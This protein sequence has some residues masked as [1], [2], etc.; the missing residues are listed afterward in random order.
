MTEFH[1]E[2]SGEARAN[3]TA[4]YD[5]IA[6]SSPSG[7]SRWLVAFEQAIS[8]LERLPHSYGLAPE[9]KY[10]PYELRQIMFKTR[11]GH[12][13]RAVYFVEEDVVKITHVRGPR[14]RLISVSEFDDE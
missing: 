8:R 6:A 14:Q 1:V 7:A 9:S 13:Y 2:M 3:V 10:A 4:I 5:W 11:R 12:V